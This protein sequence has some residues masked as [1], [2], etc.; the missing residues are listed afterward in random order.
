VTASSNPLGTIDIAATAPAPLARLFETALDQ[1]KPTIVR[2]TG[3]VCN[4]STRWLREFLSP[5][6]S[7]EPKLQPTP[8]M[9]YG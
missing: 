1:F 5:I 8:P 4:S 6:Q 9:H 3:K 2:Q 7:S